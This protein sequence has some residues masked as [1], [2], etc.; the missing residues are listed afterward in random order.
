MSKYIII[1]DDDLDGNTAAI[2]FMWKYGNIC[3]FIPCRIK[4]LQAEFDKNKN[5]N[6]DY[7]HIFFLDLD[8]SQYQDEINKIAKLTKV[9]VIDHHDT[10]S[11]SGYVEGV[12]KLIDSNASSTAKMVYKMLQDGNYTH[13]QNL[14]VFHADDYDS[15][16]LKSEDSFNLNIIF[17]EL[18]YDKWTIFKKR[19]FNGF[20]GFTDEDREI[21]VKFYNNLKV[22]FKQAEKH[23]G[24][25]DG[26]Y[27]N[28]DG[29]LSTLLIINKDRHHNICPSTMG[30][31]LKRKD[32]YDILMFVS[33][34]MRISL[35]KGTDNDFDLSVCAASVFKGGGHADAAGGIMDEDAMNIL[36]S[37]G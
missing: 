29:S 35:R 21:I 7:N 22:S 36:E 23:V 15:F 19:F 11:K 13:N 6:I 31:I 20:N 26:E 32:K 17:S 3:D 14:L 34:G 28:V 37:M 4:D 2:Q 5:Y 1:F 10:H 30:R 33:P 9:T 25:I 8:T 24:T 16:K 27:G 18:G 12:N